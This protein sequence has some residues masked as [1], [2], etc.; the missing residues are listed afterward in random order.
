MEIGEPMRRR[1]I[2]PNDLPVEAP[3]P[4]REPAKVEPVKEPV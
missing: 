2:V 3:Q 1:I 4:E